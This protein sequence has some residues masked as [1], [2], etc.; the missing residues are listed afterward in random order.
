[1]YSGRLDGIPAH[2]RRKHQPMLLPGI[3]LATSLNRPCIRWLP[4]VAA[5]VMTR[6]PDLLTLAQVN[7]INI[8][9]TQSIVLASHVL[10]C[11]YRT[12]HGSRTIAWVR[13]G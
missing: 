7:S 13:V 4:Q 1:M 10:T 12:A 8:A 3:M 5:I 2:S 9:R 11:S 6:E